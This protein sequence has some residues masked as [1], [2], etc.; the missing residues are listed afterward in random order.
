MPLRLLFVQDIKTG[1]GS[2]SRT[3]V[4]TGDGSVSRTHGHTLTYLS[5]T[6]NRPLS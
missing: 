5:V 4:K 6:R 2:V 1:D 3:H